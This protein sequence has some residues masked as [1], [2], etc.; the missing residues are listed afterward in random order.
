VDQREQPGAG[1]RE[2]RHRFG[3]AVDR[4]APGLAKEE[5][6]RGDQRAGVA[7]ADPPD[8]VD[9]VERPAD[10]S[11]VAPDADTGD[12]QISQRVEQH[13]HQ[14]EGD[15]E[16]DVPPARRLPRDDLGDLVGHR[17]GGVTGLDEQRLG[18]NDGPVEDVGFLHDLDSSSGLRLVMRAR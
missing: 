8:E 15:A 11:V 1:D 13:H 2:Q 17:P 16:A 9:D 6:N 14:Q 10:R 4:G 7:D 12:E 3:E 18:R 5:Q